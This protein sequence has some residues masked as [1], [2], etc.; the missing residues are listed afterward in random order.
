MPFADELIGRHTVQNLISA[1]QT[2]APAAELTALRAAPALIEPLSLRE[3]AD[4]LRDALLADLPGDYAA[5]ARTVRVA[6]DH[7][8]QFTGWL[9]WP[10]TSAL[11]TRAVQEGGAAAFDDAMHLLASLTGRLSSEFAIRPC[12]G[13]ISTAPSTSSWAAGPARPTPTCAG[14]PP[15]APA[16]TFP[17]RYGSRTSWPVPR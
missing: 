17:G 9:I 11:A 4:L 1:V 14:W 3:R 10:V 8:P 13:T 16:P 7:A 2:A 12:C 15:K 6:R 5:L